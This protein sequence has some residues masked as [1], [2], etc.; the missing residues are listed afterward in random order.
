MKDRASS[1]T[2]IRPRRLRGAKRRSTS[3]T[4]GSRSC[5]LDVFGCPS[6]LGRSDGHRLRG[7]KQN[8]ENAAAS[9][10]VSDPYGPA[11]GGCNVP[12]DDQSQSDSLAGDLL[13]KLHL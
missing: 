13:F 7:G 3:R 6:S 1:P 4:P 11:V 12:A 5:W 2:R 9:H 10:I 8:V